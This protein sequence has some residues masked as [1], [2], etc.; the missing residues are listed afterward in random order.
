MLDSRQISG[1]TSG[2][3]LVWNLSGHVTVQITKTSVGSNG[4]LSGLFFGGP[5]GAAPPPDTTPPTVAFSTP[6]P[7]QTL[8]GTTTVTATATD[9]VG[10]AGVQFKLDGANLGAQ[11][12]SAPYTFSWDSTKAANGSHT[13]SAVASDAAGNQST[14]SVTITVQ[15]SAPPVSSATAQFAGLDT[16][17][18]GS[19]QGAYGGDGW[20]M[21]S[22][23]AS[24]PAYAAVTV[25]S[26][27]TYVWA[28][29]TTDTRGLQKPSAI[30]RLAAAWYAGGIFTI[31][32]NLTDGAT[33]KVAAYC[34]D[35]DSS[36]RVQT[37]DVLD[38]SGNVLDTRSLSSFNG[39]QYPVWNITGHVTLRFTKTAGPNALV[40]GSFSAPP[41]PPRRCR[42]GRHH[43]ALGRTNRVRDSYADGERLGPSRYR[44]RAVHGGRLRRRSRHHRR[45]LRL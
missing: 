27:S 6:L 30:G 37:V 10:V 20:M 14:A 42:H 15:N 35:W 23:P 17:T 9:N 39:G 31:D 28:A 8:S 45:S 36:A 29:S 12:L 38:T 33:H 26:A 4:V 5:V 7:G 24:L 34:A 16:T 11:M 1:F 19:W 2:E 32:L 40:N 22:L 44:Q 13:L 3:Y 18:S 41:A 43:G 25:N 21:A